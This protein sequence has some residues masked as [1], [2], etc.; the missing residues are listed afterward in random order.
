MPRF[1][2]VVMYVSKF[3]RLRQTPSPPFPPPLAMERVGGEHPYHESC[4]KKDL[5]SLISRGASRNL[6]NAY[7]LFLHECNDCAVI[8]R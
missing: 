3:L 2:N 8:L 7:D 1:Q 5:F 4:L 6:I